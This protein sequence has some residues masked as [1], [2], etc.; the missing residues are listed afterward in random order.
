MGNNIMQEHIEQD[1][2]M[3]LAVCAI[4]KMSEAGADDGQIF[5]TKSE[6]RHWDFENGEFSK[7][8]TTFNEDSNVT[9]YKQEK[10]G[11][12]FL[13]KADL[14]SIDMA[15]LDAMESSAAAQPDDAEGIA[16][17]QEMICA[18]KGVLEPDMDRLFERVVEMKEELK[19]NH[20]HV[21]IDSIGAN[22]YKRHLVYRNTSGTVCDEYTGSYNIS[23][24]VVGKQ[25]DEV[26][27]RL[28]E[29]VQLT[30]L[31]KPL[32]DCGSFRLNVWIAERSPGAKSMEE[33]FTGTVLMVPNEVR[34]F[35]SELW[36]LVSRESILDGTSVWRD[37][38]GCQ[39]ADDRLTVC[40]DP[41]AACV[42]TGESITF[43]GFRP[44]PYEFIK[45][46]VLQYFDLDYFASKKTGFPMKKNYSGNKII[47]PGNCSL[48][49][50]V[51]HIDNG[52]LL[53]DYAGARADP[54]GNFSG[55]AT[56]S[57]RIRGGKIA[58]P[59]K[60]TS[61]SGNFAD[62]AMHIRDI[63]METIE[64]GFG[65]SPFLSVDGVVISG[66]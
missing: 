14:K 45:N 20:P 25:G 18:E 42:C 53:V 66:K 54:N 21:K 29:N 19:Q 57:F 15:V 60:E 27:G 46:G 41:S 26:T 34:E 62:M 63:S 31:E 43:D 11:A 37:R 49:D 10:R 16:P 12:R 36:G 32:L 39:V 52:I 65:S 64:D 51:R 9:V 7:F 23:L 38:L 13:N 5:V 47:L 56:N 48:E 33:K 35:V 17:N 58:E 59:L 55:V 6:C 30:D 3:D 1:N 24:S 28:Y 22:Y 2:I 4:K 40:I 61:I 50:M 8:V 44:E